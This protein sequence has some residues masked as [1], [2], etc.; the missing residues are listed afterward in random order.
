MKN[1]IIFCLFALCV[2]SVYGAKEKKEKVNPYQTKGT[3]EYVNVTSKLVGV[4]NVASYKKSGKEMIGVS[5]ESATVEFWD[6]EGEAKTAQAIFTF[7][8]KK[9]IVDS[10]IASWNKKE[11]TIT[12]DKYDILCTVDYKID[13]K[14][15]LVYLENQ[16]NTVSLQGSGDQ[17]INF[18]GKEKAFIEAQANM[19]SSGG[20]GN[21]AMAGV[22]KSVSGT[23]F[24]PNVPDQVNY[25]NLTDTSVDLITITKTNF[26]LTK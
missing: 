11:T 25:K 5:F 8:L 18:E 15:V 22:L 4:W 26:K 16:K 20:L 21:L 1:L 24:V 13:P 2:S 6:F 7:V 3:E 17:L 9:E 14:G 10:R 19:K 12:V 23:D